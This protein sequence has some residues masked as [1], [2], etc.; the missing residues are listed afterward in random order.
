MFIPITPYML[1][2]E[3][4][5]NIHVVQNIQNSLLG[6]HLKTY[7]SVSDVAYRINQH[8]WL[9]GGQCLPPA[10]TLSVLL[11]CTLWHAKNAGISLH[12]GKLLFRLLDILFI[13]FLYKTNQRV[14]KSGSHWNWWRNSTLKTQEQL[15]S[16]LSHSREKHKKHNNI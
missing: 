2:S 7:K 1:W 14:K 5:S 3:F 4:Y 9:L 8:I 11:L 16:Q 13:C 12:L 10:C 6:A 15:T